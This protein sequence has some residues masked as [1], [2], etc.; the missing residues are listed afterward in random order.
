MATNQQ[1]NLYQPIFRRQRK[2]ISFNTLV[3]VTVVFVLALVLISAVGGWKTNKLKR[4]GREL[5]EQQQTL[6]QQ[7]QAATRQ[8]SA[9]RDKSASPGGELSELQSELQAHQYIEQMLGEFEGPGSGGFSG[10]FQAF[11]RQV[12]NGLWITGFDISNGG[13]D[14]LISGGTLTPDLVAEFISRLSNEKQLQG[15]HFSVLHMD[16]ADPR[17]GWVAFT[18]SSAEISQDPP[19]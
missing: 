6:L 7:L 19:K 1:I 3:I 2:I 8:V 12:V 11:T 18:L 9:W 4:N 14:I 13:R 15:M 17:Q 10:F 5:A 16:R